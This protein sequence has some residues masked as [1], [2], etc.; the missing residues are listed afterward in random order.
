MALAVRGGGNDSI[1]SSLSPL[2]F[3]IFSSSSLFFFGLPPLFSSLP[4]LSSFLLSVSPR[5]RPLCCCS[6][7]ARP[8]SGK[9]RKI[10]FFPCLTRLGEEEDPQC[11]QN[12]TVSGFSFFFLNQQCMKRRRFGQ[13]APFHLNENGAKLMSKYKSVLNL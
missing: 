12:G 1:F 13:I 7:T 4:S 8:T 6:S 11:H 10:F 2:F 9:R 5:W 3:V